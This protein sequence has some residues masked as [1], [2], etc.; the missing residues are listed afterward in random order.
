MS[1]AVFRA[2]AA[3][4]NRPAAS[5]AIEGSD[6]SRAVR[7]SPAGLAACE[8]SKS[9]D[10]CNSDECESAKELTECEGGTHYV[11]KIL[12]ADASQ[13]QPLAQSHG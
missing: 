1:R 6:A 11:A 7:I 10:N 2:K 9:G 8:R 4:V 13:M 3:R 5:S 12:M